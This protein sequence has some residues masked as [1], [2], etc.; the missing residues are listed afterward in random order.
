[1]FLKYRKN[2]DNLREILRFGARKLD[3]LLP[4][5]RLNVKNVGLE[6]LNSLMMSK[7]HQRGI[8]LLQVH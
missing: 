8:Y 6:L 5:E 7:K 2:G 1:V 4:M 3:G